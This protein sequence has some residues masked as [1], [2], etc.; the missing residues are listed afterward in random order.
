VRSPRSLLRALFGRFTIALVV[1]LAL[2]VGGLITVNVIIDNKI[3]SIERVQLN[4]APDTDPGDPANFLLIGSDTRAFVA[5][6][7]DTEQFCEVNCDTTQRSDTIMV[8]HVDPEQQTGYLVSFPRDLMVDIPDVGQSKINAAFNTGPQTVI[9]TLKDNYDIDIHHYLEVDFESFRGIVD[10]MGGV[11][12]YLDSPARDE[13]SL[14]EIPPIFAFAPGC[15]VLD[16]RNALGYVRSR[17]YEQYIDDDLD[18]DLE[19]V[20]TG[21][22]APDIHR[23]ERQQTFMRRL[24]AEAVKKSINDPLTANDIA[25]EAITKLKADE[26]LGRSDINKLINAFR[27]VDVNDPNGSIQ[28]LTIPWMPDP[29]NPLGSLL[30]KQPEAEAVLANLRDFGP[31]AP[32]E[33]GPSPSTIRVRVFNGSG[34]AGEADQTSSRLQ[35]QGFITA[36]IGNNP[37]GNITTTEIRYRPGSDD[38][39]REVQRYVGGVGKLVRDGGIVEADVVLVLGRDFNGVTPPAGAAL[40]ADSA[41]PT[42][43]PAATSPSGNGSQEQPA[44]DP[45]QC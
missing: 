22:D 6:A 7:G 29:S 45:T 31:V 3:N 5:D 34:V 43:A 18:G 2:V 13:I 16:G 37:G 44:P 8:I 30:L 40:P 39:A 42:N 17:N 38:K 10:A 41:P 32:D 4:T 24:A 11:A 25:D 20:K 33:Q 28:M 23:I 26:G 12:I 1:A 35:Q 9:D 14:F 27:N 15:Y 21:L 19:W 36:G